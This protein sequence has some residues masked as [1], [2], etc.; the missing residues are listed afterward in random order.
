MQTE[1]P[2]LQILRVIIDGASVD[3]DFTHT[4]HLL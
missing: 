1:Q 3:Q 2:N 4:N